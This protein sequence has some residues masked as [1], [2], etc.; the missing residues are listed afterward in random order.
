MENLE[1]I[2]L[3][4]IDEEVWTMRGFVA[5]EALKRKPHI[6]LFFI[7]LEKTGCAS[8]LIESLMK[9]RDTYLFFNEHYREIFQLAL[10]NNDDEEWFLFQW[11][12]LPRS[13]VRLAVE[14]VARDMARND[15]GLD[16]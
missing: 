7:K 11:N 10:D 3:D 1:Q 13:I 4:I 9:Y 8:W 16:I 6:E 14:Q 12:D 2:L 15:L 5:E